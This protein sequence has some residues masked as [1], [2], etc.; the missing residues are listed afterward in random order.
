MSSCNGDMY[1]NIKEYADSETVYP[2]GYDQDQVSLKAGL[3]RV[4]IYLM[5]DLDEEPYLPKAKKTVVE[6]GDESRTFEPARTFVNITGLSRPQTYHF[7]IFTEDE[8][9]NR[10]AP[11]EISGKALTQED[12]NSIVVFTSSSGGV[13]Y[14]IIKCLEAAGIF[15]FCSADYNYTD[16]NNV[17]QSGK[18]KSATFVVDNLPTGQA[19]QINVNFHIL[20]TGTIDTLVFS[21]LVE[22]TTMSQQAFDDYINVT[23][24][25]NGAIHTV[26]AAAPCTINGAD[27]D[28]GGR[29]I[30]FHKSNLGSYDFPDYRPNGGDVNMAY[31]LSQCE[32]FLGFGWVTAGD[33]YYWTV[34]VQDPGEYKISY[35]Q[36]GQATNATAFLTIDEFD[37]FGTINVP[38]TNNYFAPVWTDTP[39]VKLSAGKHKLKWT[40]GT[41]GYNFY[42]LRITKVD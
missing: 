10:S 34:Y 41:S 1:D 22:V 38:N 40:Y 28:L 42:G 37:F 39:S 7:K 32:G 15:T 31:G 20:P 26:S 36:G 13:S 29:E 9:G 14:G 17:E 24:P 16:A 19:S 4:E 21:N 27:Y 18:S 23:Q 2:A 12:V 5:A 33:W 30:A 3:E 6:F 11:V 25:F 35:F 8:F